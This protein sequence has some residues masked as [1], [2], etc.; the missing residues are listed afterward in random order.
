MITINCHFVSLH[1]SLCV[2]VCSLWLFSANQKRVSILLVTCCWC[3]LWTMDWSCFKFFLDAVFHTCWHFWFWST[4]RQLLCLGSGPRP[5]QNRCES[6]PSCQTG[7]ICHCVG[8]LSY[9]Y[10]LVVSVVMCCPHYSQTAPLKLDMKE[11]SSSRCFW[12]CCLLSGQQLLSPHSV[13]SLI[14]SAEKNPKV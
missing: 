14:P 9:S 10:L 7:F 2:V 8:A 13:F 3:L 4:R 12:L 6:P 5:D 11:F 1:Y